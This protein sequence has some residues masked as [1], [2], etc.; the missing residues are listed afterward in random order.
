[1]WQSGLGSISL[2]LINLWS[3]YSLQV[4]RWVKFEIDSKK[5]DHDHDRDPLLG[6]AY[7]LAKSVEVGF[8]LGQVPEQIHPRFTENVDEMRVMF[9][10]RD[11]EER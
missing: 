6:T 3:N 10:M 7:L 4:F 11:R 9:L 1:M 8:G 5:Y 2:P